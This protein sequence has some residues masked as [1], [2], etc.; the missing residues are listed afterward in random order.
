MG[1]SLVAQVRAV[2]SASRIFQVG[3]SRF[4][5]KQD[6]REQLRGEGLAATSARVAGRTSIAS[7]RT[8]DA[9]RA[10]T[11]DFARFVEAQGVFRVQDLRPEHATA[12]LDEKL[13]AGCS[14]NTLRTYGAALGKF[15][16]ALAR[17]PRAMNVPAEAR[18]SPGL[19]AAR[20]RCNRHAVRLDGERRAYT[21]TPGLVA[22]VRDDGHRLAARLQL[23]SGFRVSEVLNLGRSS[24]LG[25]TMDPVTKR[26]CGLVLVKGKGGFGRVQYVP[27]ATFRALETHLNA[28]AG[29]M[30]IGYK[31][32]LAD[33]HRAANET[34]Q[35]WG[36]THGL[37]HNY[38]R[39]FVAEAAGC[40]L[41]SDA[42][43]REAMERVGHHR[44]SELRT[45]CR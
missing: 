18:I 13:A 5:D 9:Y 16:V 42:V 41:S 14:C 27:A 24:L 39:T 36:G 29:G 38:V 32:Y 40:G 10:V 3:K 11:A 23:E 19:K 6:V 17:A 30:G 22:T 21:D 34:G 8:Y 15:D 26:W 4:R 28:H 33:L 2:W 25:E 44:V 12:F 43:M 37:R 35:S 31:A 20:Q 1:R 7:Y 45:Y